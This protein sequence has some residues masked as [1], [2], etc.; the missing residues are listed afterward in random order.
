MN[1][2]F[3]ALANT[4]TAIFPLENEALLAINACCTTS[5]IKKG[6]ILLN[7]GEQDTQM[8]FVVSGLVKSCFSLEDHTGDFIEKI[9]WVV[10]E[11]GVALSVVSLF[12]QVPSKEYLQA[13]E[14]THLI[15]INFDQLNQLGEQYNS[16][17]KLVT[18][19]TI[20]YLVLYDK[21][22]ALFRNAKPEERFKIF[23]A[24]YP[25]LMNRLSKKEIA[26]YLDIAPGTLSRV[27]KKL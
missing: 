12:N 3:S 22:I 19:W 26:S 8:R 1:P 21:R 10:A 6:T 24:S 4:I 18:K 16:I 2:A 15:S 20:A 11:G 9:N 7:L 27:L 5:S 17:C 23:M 13:I 25:T 14:D